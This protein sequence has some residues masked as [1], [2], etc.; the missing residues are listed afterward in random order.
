MSLTLAVSPSL[1]HK[2]NY[3]FSRS[4]G[5]SRYFEAWNQ[6]L[7][8]TSADTGMANAMGVNIITKSVVLTQSVTG[9]L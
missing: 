9:L 8:G 2:D 7:G 4:R 3:R 5:S 6:V 1:S